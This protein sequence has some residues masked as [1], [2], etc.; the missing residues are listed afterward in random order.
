MTIAD[1]ARTDILEDTYSAQETTDHKKVNDILD[2]SRGL[3]R[4]SLEET[5]ALLNTEAP[6]LVEKIFES[7][8]YVKE[9]IYGKRIV[10]FAPLYISNICRNGC[11]YCSFRSDNKSTV[12]RSLS[13][14]EIKDQTGLL[15]DQGHK[16]LLLVAGE[17]ASINEGKDIDY[18]EKAVETVYS[19]GSDGKSIRRININCA[20]LQVPE[21]RRLKK[22][23]IG[24]Y[25]L[26]QETYHPET[27]KKVH[28][29]GPKSDYENRLDAVDRA[30]E[31]GIDDIGV[32]VLY[33][34][35]DYRFETLAMLRH[36]EYLEEKHGVGPH[37]ISVPRIEPA[38]GCDFYEKTP[39]RVSDRD[40]KKLVAV[41][42]LSVP[43]TGL[44]LSTRETPVMRNDL[45]SLGISQISAGSKT[46]PGGYSSGKKRQSAGGQFRLS[47]ER[48]LEEIIDTLLDRGFLPSFCTACYRTERTGRTFMGIA[49]PG[50]IKGMCRVNAL[51]TLSE[52]LEDYAGGKVRKK[53]LEV[54]RRALSDMEGGERSAAEKILGGIRNGDRDRYV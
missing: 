16:R 14:D 42:R 41:L 30:F 3:E 1:I 35:Y 23:G 5:S 32:G 49:K 50:G 20:P 8:N 22:T 13:M 29:Y 39:Y 28:P 21:F 36:V 11:L 33:G 48:S 31:A 37:T 51:S 15:I 52:Y 53:G 4:L 40:F 18:F 43:Y 2:K 19:A 45:V 46:S 27:Y 47:D 44:I 12:R 6:E 26:F 54:I 10:L 17:S 38:D 24:T 25:Q 34:L 7:A 9:K